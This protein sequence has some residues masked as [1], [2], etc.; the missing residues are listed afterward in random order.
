MR[1]VRRPLIVAAAVTA[2]ALAAGPVQATSLPSGERFLGNASKGHGA[3]IEPAY[4]YNTGDLT[5][6]L[7]PTGAP[8]PSKANEHAIA[9]L[10]IV[11]YPSSYP[12]WTLS[13]M[14]VPGNCPDHD[15][16][17]AGAATAIEPGV[18]G[19]DP[20]AVPGHD[21][22]IGLARTGGD[23][24]VAW[25]VWV[26]LF[27]NSGAANTHITT[28]SQLQTALGDGDAISV[29]SGIIFN[30]SAVSASA[31]WHGTPV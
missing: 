30:C 12:G 29:D 23:W 27:T 11:V 31:Y 14:G 26:I 18:Y 16:L 10:Y 24:N 17:I 13:C 3:V 1:L 15:G 7:T 28:L 4:D 5:Y 25:H 22:L 8:F 2:L 20:A 19:T 9:P 6:I 21:H